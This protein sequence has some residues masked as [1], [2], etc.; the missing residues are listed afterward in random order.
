MIG[1]GI[2]TGG[3]CTDAV[4]IDTED[5][6]VLSYGKTLTTKRDL[7]EG[8]LKALNSLDESLV[9]KAE[10]LSLSTTLAT[11]ACVEGKGGRAKLVFIGVKKNA[12]EKMQGTYGL[13][14][15]R[16]IYFLEGD[17]LREKEP[18]GKPDWDR[19]RKDVKESFTAYDSVAVVQINPKYND[20]KY[21]KE[22]EEIISEELGVPC[23]RGYEL[24]QEINVQRRGATALLNAKLLPVMKNFFDSIDRSLAELGLN[25]PIQVVKSDGSIMN[26]AY[27]MSR[28]VETLLCGPAASIIGAMELSDKKDGLIVDMGGTTSDVA[29]VKNGVPVT[30]GDGISIGSWKTMV[31]GVTIDTFALGG[32]SAVYCDENV[33]CLDKSR[34]VPLCMV[35]AQYPS[36]QEKL[37]QLTDSYGVYSYPA[38]QFLLL[39]NVPENLEK[40]SPNERKLIEALQD[41]PL[42]FA[43]AAAAV[44]I[45]PYVFKF[46]RLEDEGVIIRC[47]I[48]PTDVMHLYGDYTD[49]DRE[50]SRLGVLY[51]SYALRMPFEDICARIYEM[52]KERLYT[53]LVR[54]LLKYETGE[55]VSESDRKALEKL[56]N[57]IFTGKQDRRFLTPDFHAETSLIGIGAPTKIFMEDVAEKLHA[58]ADF[59]PYAMVANAIGAAVG[60][61]V[62]EYVVR[63]EAGGPKSGMEGYVVTGGEKVE[64]FE[65][66]GDAVKRAKELAE[67]RACARARAQGA[68][69]G[70]SCE[71]K[72]YEDYYDAAGEGTRLFMGTQ[73]VGRAAKKN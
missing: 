50:A 33:L 23:V 65:Y 49:Y 2:D 39:Q 58:E 73:V 66:Y 42:I 27:A 20:G 68:G 41:G 14:P 4:I 31:K 25:L 18:Q 1:I 17:P 7:K 19:F 71:V 40:Y 57:F 5:N 46:Q 24:Y 53:N 28:P 3:T 54:I 52:A 51:L 36:V 47:G 55:D 64:T 69:G 15:V 30:C 37:R 56:T 9:R 34:I 38:N 59:P 45:S 61:V 10:Y 72:V 22:A 32:D 6:R 12:V 26:R 8:I 13:P 43:E 70:L 21:E 60:S 63:V 67:E 11:N 44:G 62:S 35:S 29:L 16:E 48:T